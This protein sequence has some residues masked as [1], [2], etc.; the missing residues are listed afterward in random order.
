MALFVVTMKLI[1]V[2]KL[3]S[4]VFT[5]IGADCGMYYRMLFRQLLLTEGFLT[6]ITVESG[7]LVCG[8]VSF[9]VLW[10]LI[11]IVAFAMETF[12]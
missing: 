7:I 9:Q 12:I 8:D 6:Q 3:C 10:M 5:F 4:A 2:S 1:V 11:A